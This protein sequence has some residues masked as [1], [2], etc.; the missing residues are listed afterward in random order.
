[1]D[2]QGNLWVGDF[3]TPSAADGEPTAWTVFDREGRVLA[4]IGMPPRFRIFDIGADWVLGVRTDELGVE[5]VELYRV[6]RP[7]S[8]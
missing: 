8:E 4:E 5:H 1:M 2:R 3:R 6:R 7:A